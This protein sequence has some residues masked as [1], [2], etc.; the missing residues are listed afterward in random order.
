MLALG[1][2]DEAEEWAKTAQH[3]AAEDDSASQ[4]PAVGTLAVV[5]SR[6]GDLE[7]ARASAREAVAMLDVTDQLAQVADAH[8]DLATVLEAAAKPDEAEAEFRREL[9]VYER[10]GHLV[11][12]DGMR[13]RLTNLLA[14]GPST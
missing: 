7:T 3:L 8:S 14:S 1:R 4:G 11:G 9:D 10:K 12:A 5:T 2:D 13:R 6:R